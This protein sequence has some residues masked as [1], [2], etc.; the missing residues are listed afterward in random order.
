MLTP[1]FLL[2]NGCNLEDTK[3]EILTSMNTVFYVLNYFPVHL[4]VF[5]DI[6]VLEFTTIMTRHQVK[7]QYYLSPVSVHSCLHKKLK[8]LSGLKD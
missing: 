4:P 3:P 2:E 8:L 1:H 6:C 5:H 7:K